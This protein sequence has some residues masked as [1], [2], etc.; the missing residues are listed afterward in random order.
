MAQE[1][2]FHANIT[3]KDSSLLKPDA[4]RTGIQLLTTTEK[5]SFHKVTAKQSKL[6]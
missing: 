6:M 5:A 2:L 4:L 3:E 1:E